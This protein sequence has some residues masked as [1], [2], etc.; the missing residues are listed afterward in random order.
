[1]ETLDG[2]LQSSGSPLGPTPAANAS[3]RAPSRWSL[4]AGDADA[5]RELGSALG[6][7]PTV[8]Q[9]LLHRGLGEVAAAREYLE[10]RLAGLTLPDAMIDRG[11]ATDRIASAIRRRERIAIFGD[12]DVDGTT[13]SAILAEAITAMGGEVVVLVA[14]RFAGGY[15]FSGPALERVK[16]TGATLLI[17]CDCGS[18]GTR[19]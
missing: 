10:P 18:A 15:G 16:T 9:V 7:S 12:Y 11:I 14:N 4:R 13:S 17:T 8:A 6:L 5:A 2:A 1:M 19:W 3:P